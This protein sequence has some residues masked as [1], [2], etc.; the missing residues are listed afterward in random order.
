[1]FHHQQN[2]V[3]EFERQFARTFDAAYAVAFPYGRSALWAFFKAQGIEGAEVVQPA[4][5]CVVVA[6]ATV[7][8]G[9]I[10]RFVDINLDSYGMDLNL[11]AS[12]LTARTRAVIATHLFGYPLDADR[13]EAVVHDAERKYGQKIW[14]IQD[15]A[16]AFGATWRGKRVCNRSDVALFGLN[17]SKTVTSIFGGMVTTSNAEV[18]HR[19][20]EWRDAHFVRRGLS[21]TVSRALYLM[22]VY[23]AFEPHVYSMV[24]WLE[25]HTPLLD[26]FTKAYHLDGIIRLPPDYC[27]A[28]VDVEAR[29]GLLQ[30]K[31]Y[32]EIIRHRTAL[33]RYYDEHLK[34]MPTLALPPIIEGAT[35]SHY[36]VRVESRQVWLTAARQANIELGCLIDYSIPE[37]PA[38]QAYVDSEFPR[39]HEAR[40]TV[41]NLP[42]HM[43]VSNTDRKRVV[44]VMASTAHLQACAPVGSSR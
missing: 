9:N 3:E 33:A 38:Y 37:M 31:K 15:C 39:A 44:D 23:Q 26:R 8:S 17:I 32:S 11:L 2:A 25:E 7:L 42:V 5:T 43:G 34:D 20:R 16:H 36:P 29:V 6:H 4:Y 27:D 30:L 22:A 28:M 1:M 24:K 10:P 19:L 21:K 13:V 41:I 18:A 35:Y 14:I 40:G 12:A